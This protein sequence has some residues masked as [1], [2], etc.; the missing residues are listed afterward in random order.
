MV[1]GGGNDPAAWLHTGVFLGGNET[2]SGKTNENTIQHNA[3]WNCTHAGIR[4][5]R[6]NEASESG[7][8]F[9]RF[10]DNFSYAQQSLFTRD[11][12]GQSTYKPTGLYHDS[13]EGF[14]STVI[15]LNA[16]VTLFVKLKK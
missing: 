12:F 11:E 3:L 15:I 5:S 10:E 7:A 14:H 6:A 16:S 2:G 4:Q 9:K 8:Y 1:F 13:D